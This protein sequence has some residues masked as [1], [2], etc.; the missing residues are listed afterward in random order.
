M[1]QLSHLVKKY[2]EKKVVNDISIELPKEKIIAFIGS[3]GAGKSTVL[4]LA[5]RLL[6]RDS[7]EVKIDGTKL[8]DWRNEE[9]AKRL[10][11]LK[12]SNHLNVRLTVREL[13]SFGRFPYSKEKLTNEDTKHIDQA[14]EYMEL[15]ELENRY[16]DELS[17]GQRQMAY[18]A[19]VIAQD[20]EY[21]LLDEPL[22][23]LDMRHSVK[24]MK[25]LRKLVDELH[26]T[27]VVVIHD[28]NF[29]SHYADYVVA[30]K[31][32]HIITHGPTDEVIQS[33]VLNDIYNMDI[34]IERIE[35]KCVC[36][37]YA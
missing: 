33:S 16:L 34:S 11:I 5:S 21:I 15:T 9:L 30:M 29:V 28:I 3:N 10:S 8:K 13:V 31:D 24:I 7:G 20:T 37:Y 17:G 14:I 19:M 32:G 2:G 36:L 23:N 4:S 35:G 12:Q 27:I 25:V 6:K 22:N 1:I 26:K 18:I